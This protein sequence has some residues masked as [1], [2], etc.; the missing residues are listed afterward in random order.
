[1]NQNPEHRSSMQGGR[2]LQWV[3][4]PHSGTCECD[5]IGGE[6]SRLGGVW[7]EVFAD[8]IKLRDLEIRSFWITRGHPVIRGDRTQRRRP[9]ED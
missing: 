6:R 7:G 9:C 8:V 4:C 3:Q 5:L 2:S 1:M